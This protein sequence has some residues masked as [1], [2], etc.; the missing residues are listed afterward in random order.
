MWPLSASSGS[1]KSSL[2]RAGLLPAVREG[3]LLGT[4]DR[5]IVVIKPG[6]QP[7]LRLLRALS[8][9]GIAPLFGSSAGSI[10]AWRRCQV[11]VRRPVPTADDPATPEEKSAAGRL[12]STDGSLV[13]A[14]DES[15]LAA[16]AKMLVVMDQFEE[17]FG[18]RRAGSGRDNVASRDEAAA[19]VAMLLRTAA[20]PDSRVRIVLTMRSV[21]RDC[22][23]SWPAGSLSRHQLLVPRL[24]PQPNGRSDRPPRADPQRRFLPFTFEEGLGQSNYQSRRRPARPTAADAARVDAHL[25]ACSERAAV[26]TH[27]DYHTC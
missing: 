1:G 19:F 27:E 24:E 6:H 12:L 8:A 14:L 13:V 18:F 16:E 15:S 9:E 20:D 10:S 25:E 2:V 3:F 21:H 4:T 11:R 26:L 23:R 17:L 22:E 5:R 7:Y